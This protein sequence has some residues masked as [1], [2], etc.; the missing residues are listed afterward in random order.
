M[1][2]V[3]G[4]NGVDGALARKTLEMLGIDDEGLDGVGRKIL[5]VI[6][7]RFEGGPV[8]LETLA[9]ALGEDRD[10]ISEVDEP[11]LIAQG[12]IRRTPQ[13]RQATDKAY[14][15]LGHSPRTLL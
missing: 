8:G 1:A 3:A 12:F 4:A 13:G 14:R 5:G 2:Q 11:Y 6:V 15:H 9:A 10:T 7:D